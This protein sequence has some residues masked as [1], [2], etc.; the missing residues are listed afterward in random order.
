MGPD[1]NAVREFL[2]P[3]EV[4]VQ[5]NQQTSFA[6]IEPKDVTKPSLIPNNMIVAVRPGEEEIQSTYWLARVD[7]LQSNTNN[8]NPKYRLT[9]YNFNS[10]T[11][12]W[13]LNKRE[14]GVTTHNAVLVAGIQFTK[15]MK[16]KVD[17]YRK[18]QYVLN[19]S[20]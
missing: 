3:V 2:Q 10:S 5:F 1:L 6:E 14:T 11:K 4:G 7:S 8:N 13:K 15:D 20:E 17:S 16:L 12:K 9:F 18:I 19:L